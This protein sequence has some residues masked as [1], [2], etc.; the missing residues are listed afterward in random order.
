MLK[1]QADSLY[2]GLTVSPALPTPLYQQLYE[3]LRAAILTGHIAAGTVLPSTRGLAEVLGISRNT[4]LNA[5]DQLAAEGYVL[6]KEGSGTVV[7]SVLP[8]HF[9][10]AVSPRKSTHLSPKQDE[11]GL[12]KRGLAYLH[13]QQMPSNPAK[14]QLKAFELGQ[15]ALDKLPFEVWGRCITRRARY[16]ALQSYG[17]QEAAGYRPLRESIAQHLIVTRGVRCTAEQV[18]IVSGSQGALDLA[19]RVLLDHGDSAWVEDPGYL[20][21]RGALIG[22]GATLVPVPVDDEGLHVAA[23]IARCPTARMAYVTPSHQFPLAVTMS[24]SRRLA[25]LEWAATAG[26]WILEDD[27]NSEYR[28]SGRPLAA[29]QGLDTHNRVIYIGTFS[30]ILFPALRLGYL[31]VPET[32]IDAFCAARRFID[33]HPPALEQAALADFM[34]EGHLTRHIRR[35]RLLYAQRRELLVGLARGAL[36]LDIHAPEAGMHLV[37]WLP[38]GVD[39]QYA[40][41]KAAEHGIFTPLVSTFSLEPSGRNGLLMG[42]ASIRE[43]EIREGVERLSR[44]FEKL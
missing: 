42:Y 43:S 7:A 6:G 44:A 39:G 19:A 41:Q 40:A 17:Y 27:Y 23:G 3:R 4:V 8:E 36:P 11:I 28:F 29:L 9:P 16:T 25:L 31:V 22:A 26:A 2:A 38:D 35:M 21:A 10:P 15:P 24:L 14:S 30:K 18:I 20:G 13:A 32:L 5:Y 1:P 34:D 33:V 12:S 37:G